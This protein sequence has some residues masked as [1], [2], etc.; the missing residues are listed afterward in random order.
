[1]DGIVCSCSRCKILSHVLSL[2][3]THRHNNDASLNYL[4]FA[5]E[6]SQNAPVH[7]G[8]ADVLGNSVGSEIDASVPRLSLLPASDDSVESPAE[9]YILST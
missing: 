2:G 7:D 4:F 9:M 5:G 3:F 1:M 6:N 8:A